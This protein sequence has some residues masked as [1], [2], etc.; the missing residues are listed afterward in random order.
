MRAPSFR[1]FVLI[2]FTLLTAC[3]S[4]TPDADGMVRPGLAVQGTVRF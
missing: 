4:F 2:A 3:E 1:G